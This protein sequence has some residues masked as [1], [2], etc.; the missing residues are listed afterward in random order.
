MTTDKN[1]QLSL[2]LINF[3]TSSS[4][5]ATGDKIIISF[6]KQSDVKRVYGIHT[7]TVIDACERINF[8]FE[9]GVTNHH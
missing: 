1:D 5:L 2:H 3:V 8:T 9:R 6:Q 7:Y 4:F